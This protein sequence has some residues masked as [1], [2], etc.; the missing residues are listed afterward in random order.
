MNYEPGEYHQCDACHH[1]EH[2]GKCDCCEYEEELD[3]DIENDGQDEVDFED[4]E[5]DEDDEGGF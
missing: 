2:C 5:E 4:D 3:W 1:G